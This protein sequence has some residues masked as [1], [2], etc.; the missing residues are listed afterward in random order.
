MVADILG[1]PAAFHHY[2]RTRADMHSAGAL[3]AAEAD[4]LGA[5]L[6]D[7]L[8]ILHNAADEQDT[9]I[10]IGYS[11]EALNDFY[12]RQ[13][14]GLEADR[15]TTG[16]PDEVTSALSDA[17]RQSGWVK[18]VDAVMAANPSV[19]PKW[20]RFRGKHRRGGTFILND[21]VC[22]VALSQRE[23]SLGQLDDSISLNIPTRR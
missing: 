2:A 10:L 21:Q 4:A 3:A 12:T 1:D 13:Q 18:C 23:S 17:L 15:P 5:Y 6:L 7:R 20:K 16:V 19:W 8:S 22:L 14:A 9:R 11:C